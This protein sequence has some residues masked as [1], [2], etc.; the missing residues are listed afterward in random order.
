MMTDV[1][2]GR[3]GAVVEGQQHRECFAGNEEEQQGVMF[4]PGR[5][6]RR[7]KC[8]SEGS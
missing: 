3:Q 1:L 2:A 7:L 8:S 4:G 5:D 6:E